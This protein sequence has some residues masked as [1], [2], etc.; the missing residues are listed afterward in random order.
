MLARANTADH[1]LP[2]V[3]LIAFGAD[4]AAPSNGLV[5][6]CSQGGGRVSEFCSLRSI[7]INWR[8]ARRLIDGSPAARQTGRQLLA[9]QSVSLVDLGQ[10]DVISR[11]TWPV[12]WKLEGA[13]IHIYK[14]TIP[15][16]DH[17]HHH[18]HQPV[19]RVS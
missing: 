4:S 5:V 8:R 7:I 1:L 12:G 13:Q 14:L 6:R 16:S 10:I 3:H 17:H 15:M 19:K 18:R 9:S 11:H 2:Q